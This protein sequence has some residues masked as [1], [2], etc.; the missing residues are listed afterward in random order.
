MISG[1]R[2]HTQTLEKT[3]W[4]FFRRMFIHSFHFF[5]FICIQSLLS[6]W[7]NESPHHFLFSPLLPSLHF[8]PTNMTYR[9]RFRLQALPLIFLCIY[10]AFSDLRIPPFLCCHLHFLVASVPFNSF[11]L[12]ILSFPATSYFPLLLRDSVSGLSL[13]PVKCFYWMFQSSL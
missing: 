9:Y 13:S 12:T 1:A 7:N 10:I 8:H 4:Y 6:W 5:F 3:Q 2:E 11:H